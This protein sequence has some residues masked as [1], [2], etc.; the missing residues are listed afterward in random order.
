MPSSC[1]VWGQAHPSGPFPSQFCEAPQSR[2]LYFTDK[3]PRP[4]E[5]EEVPKVTQLVRGV[6]EPQ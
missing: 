3:A 5:A 2:E 4:R 1:T 6:A